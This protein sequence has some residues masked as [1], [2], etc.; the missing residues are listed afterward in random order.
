MKM[1]TYIQ[2]TMFPELDRRLARQMPRAKK[3]K[4]LPIETALDL[5]PRK[6]RQLVFADYFPGFELR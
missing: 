5:F 3:K 1:I 6:E 4:R 2:T